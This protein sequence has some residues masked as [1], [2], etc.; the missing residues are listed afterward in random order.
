MES[1]TRGRVDKVGEAASAAPRMCRRR[2]EQV[3]AKAILSRRRGI[4]ESVCGEE[5][6]VFVAADWRGSRAALK[7]KRRGKR[8]DFGDLDVP[9][10]FMSSE[11]PWP[12]QEKQVMLQLLILC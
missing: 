11:A 8:F 9:K 6:A 12:Y 1:G 5:Y 3:R 7:N 2:L 10:S 4:Q